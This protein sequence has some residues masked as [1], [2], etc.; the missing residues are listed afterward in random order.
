MPVLNIQ[1]NR[2]HALVVGHGPAR[3]ASG[4]PAWETP[5]RRRGA[6]SEGPTLAGEDRS[7]PADGR[8]AP[9]D[10]PA[11]GRV[12]APANQAPWRRL[13]PREIE[14]VAQCFLRDE[15]KRRPL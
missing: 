15:T 3:C 8:A 7:W 1:N 6:T 14:E 4:R 5:V 2:S 11:D 9:A 12:V 10:A 13:F